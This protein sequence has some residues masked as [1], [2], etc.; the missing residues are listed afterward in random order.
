MENTTVNAGYRFELLQITLIQIDDVYQRTESLVTSRIKKIASDF[1]MLRFGCL[2][3]GHR[4][5]DSYWV[6]DG[7]HRFLGAVKADI[8]EVP[9]LIFESSGREQEASL[10]RSLNMD[11]TRV[12]AYGIYKAALAYG[13]PISK[14]VD[15]LLRKYGLDMGAQLR[16]GVFKCASSVMSSYQSGV[17]DKVL[18]VISR[19]H[20]VGDGRSEEWKHMFGTDIFVSVLTALFKQHGEDVDMSH[21]CDRIRSRLGVVAWRR[22]CAE[23]AGTGG[24]RAAKILPVFVSEYYNK[25]KRTRRL[26]W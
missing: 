3:I 8:V 10:F 7:Q 11:R 15:V 5:D 22:M 9:C 1:D 21:L 26:A 23:Q 25:G 16:D 14:G 6:V 13:D 19:C 20:R 4:G 2:V 12:G 17:L 18:C 24:N